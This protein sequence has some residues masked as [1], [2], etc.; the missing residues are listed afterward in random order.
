MNTTN[1]LGG[2]HAALDRYFAVSQVVGLVFGALFTAL[3]IVLDALGFPAHL[4]WGSLLPMGL[5]ALVAFPTICS[6][7]VRRAVLAWL[8]RLGSRGEERQAAAVA[9]LM[10][11]YSPA[12]A[13]ARGR[14]TF[15]GLPFG[16]LTAA[17]LASNADTGL[18][19]RTIKLA[20]GSCDAFTSHSWHDDGDAKWAALQAWAM[21]FEKAKGRSPML[22]LDKACINQQDVAASLACL[23]VYLAGCQQ[24]L[25]LAGKTYKERLWPAM[26]VFTF[27]RMGGALERVEITPLDTADDL[28][29][30][31]FAVENA[32]CFDD[33]DKAKLLTAIEAAFGAYA[34]FNALVRGLLVGASGAVIAP[35]RPRRRSFT[36]TP[37]ANHAADRY[38]DATRASRV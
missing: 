3:A 32:K 26:E 6:R 20:L 23:P 21:R 7:P 13:L 38:L 24:L 14:A 9:A 10:G 16:A 11:A 12:K 25:V 19:Q 8:G 15:C 31:T 29:F 22:W 30:E 5:A 37:S 2:I 34:P 4:T 17:D 18:H 27:V 36:R 33:N 28:G 1:P 35:T